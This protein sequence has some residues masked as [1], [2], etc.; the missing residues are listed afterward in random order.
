L[1]DNAF[2][3]AVAEAYRDGM[4]AL[5]RK[6]E[7]ERPQRPQGGPVTIKWTTILAF[8]GVSIEAADNTAFGLQLTKDEARRAA[9]HG[10]VSEQGYPD[11]IDPL[12]RLHPAAVVPVVR[13]AFA[14]EWSSEDTAV[15]YFLYRYSQSSSSI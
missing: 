1:L 12:T 11:W 14:A 5:W 15:S 10:C 2:S 9:L 8:A 3:G 7:P 6:V 13:E 4:M